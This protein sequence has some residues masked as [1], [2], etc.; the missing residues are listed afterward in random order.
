MNDY[1]ITIYSAYQ[2][3]LLRSLTISDM[4][5]LLIYHL[6]MIDM[7]FVFFSNYALGPPFIHQG[8]LMGLQ[9]FPNNLVK[10]I[11]YND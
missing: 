10:H 6:T 8:D 2:L 4:S 9:Y 11:K 7:L 1:R 5:L 3:Y